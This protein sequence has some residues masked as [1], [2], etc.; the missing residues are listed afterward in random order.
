MDPL[1]NLYFE[2]CSLNVEFYTALYKK[3]SND[4]LSKIKK[5]IEA[6]EARILE[7]LK[8][9]DLRILNSQEK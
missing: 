1:T 2:R 4:R 7:Y 6:H 3:E 8:Y 9:E 5:Q